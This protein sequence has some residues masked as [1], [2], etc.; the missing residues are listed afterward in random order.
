MQKYS[1]AFVKSQ[2]QKHPVGF[3][4]AKIFFLLLDNATEYSDISKNKSPQVLLYYFSGIMQHYCKLC[5]RTQI[6]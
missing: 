5:P 1:M 6:L 3:S 4:H 2:S